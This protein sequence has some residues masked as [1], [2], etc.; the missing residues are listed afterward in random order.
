MSQAPIHRHADNI[1]QW[2]VQN[3]PVPAIDLS[4]LGKR[5]AYVRE[6][7]GLSQSDLARATKFSQ[8]SIWA[9]ENDKT[10]EVSASLLGAV[11]VAL[12]ASWE[13]LLQGSRNFPDADDA[14]A[15]T[16]L[17]GIYR[18]LDPAKKVSVLEFARHLKASARPN[19][20][21][22]DSTQP[23]TTAPISGTTLT[24]GKKTSAP[25]KGLLDVRIGAGNEVGKAE[26]VPKPRRR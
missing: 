6:Q 15:E 9:L 8:P 24:T 18:A 14:L 20:V 7:R 12:S 13:F 22:N 5:V 16:E 2:P 3:R 25:S 11:S 1:S 4:T 26:R 21:T 19:P 17:V 23:Q 10:K